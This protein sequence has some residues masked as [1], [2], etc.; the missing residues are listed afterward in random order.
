MTLKTITKTIQH[1]EL[2]FT[3]QRALFWKRE[4]SLIIS[5]LH[6]GKTAYFRK[7]G[8]AVPSK[9]LNDDLARLGKMI[10]NFEAENVII[11]GDLLHAGNNTDLQIFAEWLKAFP[12]LQLR[13]IK[14]N[15]DTL[16]STFLEGTGFEICGEKL[17]IPP[18]T[19]I[20]IPEKWADR[21]SISGH[22]H[23]GVTLKLERNKYVSL[24]C[25]RYSDN[26]LVLPAFSKFTGLD[27]KSCG[28]FHC[29]PFSENLI[30]E[31]D[32]TDDVF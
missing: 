1:E 24:P 30:F 19:F 25:F 5:D 10:T 31:M 21:F 12:N 32:G 27:T 14:G 7:N 29:I 26:Q 6:I 8:I 2:V 16:K 17:H 4:Q 23:P 11:V 13:L 28:D 18:F 15:H 3:N 22:L 20:H 9:V